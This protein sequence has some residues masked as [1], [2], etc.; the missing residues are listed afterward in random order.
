MVRDIRTTKPSVWGVFVD[1]KRSGSQPSVPE[2][3]WW[4][5]FDDKPVKHLFRIMR[6]D[7]DDLQVEMIDLEKMMGYERGSDIFKSETL[8]AVAFGSSYRTSF[9]HTSLSLAAAHSWGVLSRLKAQKTDPNHEVL[10]VR[11][12]I[13]DWYLSGDMPEGALIDLSAAEP[14]YGFVKPPCD[15]LPTISKNDVQEAIRLSRL[16]KEVLVCWRG[17]VPLKYF[18]LINDINGEVL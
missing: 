10:A 18:E 1:G 11:I 6:V 9:L 4:P 8:R 16:R 7:M 12:K 14:Q 2:P 13:L 17:M 15:E 5:R 3:T